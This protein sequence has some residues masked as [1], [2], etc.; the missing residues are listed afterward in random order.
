MVVG[1]DRNVFND[2][3]DAT[4]TCLSASPP[5]TCVYSI[6]VLLRNLCIVFCKYSGSVDTSYWI[7]TTSTPRF[8][9]FLYQ[10]ARNTDSSIQLGHQV[11]PIETITALFRKRASESETFLPFISGKLKSKRE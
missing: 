9:F 8:L 3:S 11:P 1:N 5:I 10:S 2:G 6:P 7:P 4:T